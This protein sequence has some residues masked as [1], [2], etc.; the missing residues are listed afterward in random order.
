[1][2][3][4]EN[5]EPIFETDK[6]D[7]VLVGTSV[8]DL[9]VNGFQGK[10]A[11]K[12]PYILEANHKQP[13]GDLRNLGTRLTL[14][15]EGNPIISL[16]YIC[17]YPKKKFKSLDYDAL[18]QCLTTAAVEFKDKCILTTIMGSTSFDGEGSKKRI[19]KM[20]EKV[21]EGMDVDV[22]DYKQ[23]NGVEERKLKK[24]QLTEIG[25]TDNKKRQE[26]LRQLYLIPADGEKR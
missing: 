5:Q 26:I 16:L 3:I 24:K 22:Y 14:K 1:M 9:L 12:Y 11:N 6:Y 10:M 19:I 8:Y 15:R 21:F 2:R 20:M 25:V 13:Y 7:V 4:I 18:K 17:G 23:M